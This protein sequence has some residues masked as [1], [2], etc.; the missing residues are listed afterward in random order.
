MGFGPAFGHDFFSL[1]DIG[2]D[3]G[4]PFKRVAL[5]SRDGLLTL[6]LIT[7]GNT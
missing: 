4:L 1:C 7:H 6:G 3:V 5:L 2:A